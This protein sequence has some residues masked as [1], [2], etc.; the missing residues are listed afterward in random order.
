MKSYALVINRYWM[1]T[2]IAALSLLVL[3]TACTVGPDYQA[4][5]ASASQHYDPQAEQRLAQGGNPRI[6]LGKK[7]NG[8]WW[9]A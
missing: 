8:D 1:Q 3:L 4:P 2:K 5:A 7:V 6:D 9:S